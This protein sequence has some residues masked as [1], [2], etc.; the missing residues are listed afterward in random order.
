M[1]WLIDPF[2]SEAGQHALVAGSLTAVTTGVVGIWVVLRGM[3]FFS[4]ALAHGVV[5]GLALAA[6]WGFDPTL[7]AVAAAGV[8][9]GGIQ[10]VRARTGLPSDTG[11]GLLFVGMLATGV[12]ILS[13]SGQD[14]H[15]L[16]EFLFGDVLEV[17]AGDLWVPVAAAVVVVIA[18]LVLH[19]ALLA[20]AVHRDKAALLG[21][22]PGLT[23]AALLA[24][25][26]I[27]VV[28]SFR[29]VGSLLVSG[30][31]IAP[32]ATATLIARRVLTMIALAVGLGLLAVVA[33]L[34]VSHHAENSPG[35]TIAVIAVG[36]FFVGLAAKEI[37]S[38]VRPA[39][40]P[41]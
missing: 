6:V 30:L 33:G 25:V 37:R 13:G 19:R 8:T 12:M 28:A 41:V 15:E 27:A 23:E 39:L 29:T 20:L 16:E 31:L 4:D 26:A 7:G 11:I 18:V 38:R 21:L 17:G 36:E 34:I 10:L 22:R 35:A 24:L 3:A 5:P 2:R 1:D 40:E 9:V 14:E 32:A